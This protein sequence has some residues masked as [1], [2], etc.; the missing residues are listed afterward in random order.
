MGI[1]D[2]L[3]AKKINMENKRFARLDK[4]QGKLLAKVSKQKEYSK[5]KGEIKKL[6]SEYNKYSGKTERMEKGKVRRMK[7]TNKFKENLKK[8]ASTKNDAPYW[9][10]DSGNSGSSMF[11]SSSPPYWLQSE[12]KKEK[13]ER[14]K[15]ITIR[16]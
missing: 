16:L 5:K 7:I 11:G 6:E 9:M 14:G 10:K 12:E 2:K 1:V 8:R 13:K 15:S 3:R 4:K